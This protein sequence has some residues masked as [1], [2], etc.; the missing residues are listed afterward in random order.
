MLIKNSGSDV[1]YCSCKYKAITGCDE[2]KKIT[3]IGNKII[4]VV[5]KCEF[6]ESIAN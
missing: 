3:W 2:I 6:E 4:S 1:K 5:H